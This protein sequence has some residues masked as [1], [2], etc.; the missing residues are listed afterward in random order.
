MLI[1]RTVCSLEEVLGAVREIRT[2]WLKTPNAPEEVW[3]RGESRCDCRLLPG[4][5]RSNVTALG[6]DEDSMFNTFRALG[7]GLVRRQQSD[8]EWYFL[9]QHHGLKTRLLDWTHNLL[10]AVHFAL[11]ESCTKHPRARLLEQ[12]AHAPSTSIF[13]ADSPAVWIMDAG[14][15][16]VATCGTDKD[17][18]FVVDDE[19][20]NAYLPERLKTKDSSNE[21]PV[22]ILAPRSNER[23]VAQQGCFTIHGHS[24]MPI[25]DFAAT[26]SLRI[27]RLDFDRANLARV[28]RDLETCGVHC[29]SLFPD[30]DRVAERVLWV[31]QDE[32]T[33]PV[34][35]G[36]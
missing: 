24:L 8:W 18:I 14:S 28:W 5:Y 15:L 13:D 9:A 34:T 19:E 26:S 12:I 22:A 7:S 3:F 20:T 36:S 29:L 30:L 16:N 6:Y 25:Q 35:Q 4:L 33:P 1:S 11:Y 32:A 23:I 2:G 17:Y 31:C 27:A 21:K 10:A